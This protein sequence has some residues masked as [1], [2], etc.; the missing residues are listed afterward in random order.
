[1][2]MKSYQDGENILK[3]VLNPIKATNDDTTLEPICCGKED[4][5]HSRG[6][7]LG[8]RP[9]KIRKSSW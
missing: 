7:R 1:M 9:V 4:F 5:F 2:R 6:G 3:V 8:D